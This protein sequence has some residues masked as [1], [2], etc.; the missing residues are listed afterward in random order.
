MKINFK[1]LTM[2]ILS[3]FLF[4]SCLNQR[5]ESISTIQDNKKFNIIFKKSENDVFDISLKDEKKVLVLSFFTTSCGACKEEIPSLNM[6]EKEFPSQ[7]K[8][9]SVLGEKKS[10]KEIKSFINKYN[11]SYSIVSEALSVNLLSKAVGSIFGVPVTFIFKN[12]GRLFKKFSGLIPH[13][14]MRQ[15]ILQA[16]D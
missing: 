14:I 1:L 3:I 16:I 2:S 10:I 8:I 5:V 11:I 12:N 9:L 15:T 7:I 4:T 13:K 6:L